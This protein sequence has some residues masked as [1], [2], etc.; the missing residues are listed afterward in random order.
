[1]VSFGF[2]I[3]APSRTKC[4]VMLTGVMKNVTVEAKF[5]H[6]IWYEELQ[7]PESKRHLDFK[8]NLLWNVSTVNV[9]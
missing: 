1:M 9:A 5:I 3:F 8:Y 6:E 2:D 7:D 4:Y